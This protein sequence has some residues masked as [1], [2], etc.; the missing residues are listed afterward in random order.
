MRGIGDATGEADPPWE[1]A[2]RVAYMNPFSRLDP[3]TGFRQVQPVAHAQIKSKNSN[4]PLIPHKTPYTPFCFVG[5]L[6]S[7]S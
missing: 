2:S 5:G 4:M 7:T 6:C 1:A 3:E